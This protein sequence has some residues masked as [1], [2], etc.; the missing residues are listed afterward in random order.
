MMGRILC[1][2]YGLKRT[3]IAVTD[4]LKI[5]ANGLTT[6]NRHELLPFLEDYIH[7]ENVEC[8]VIGEP[9]H[10]NNEA[11]AIEKEIQQLINSVIKKYPS[12]TIERMD[13]RFTSK[14]ALKTMIDGGIKKMQRRDKAIVDKISATIILQSYLEKKGNMRHLTN[15]Q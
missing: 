15:D 14:M 3:G 6:L 1:L 5:I 2:D 7:R 10:L 9:K 4:P 13:E 8:I 11:A 12:V